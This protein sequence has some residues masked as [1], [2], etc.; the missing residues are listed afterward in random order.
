MTKLAD[1]IQKN[2]KALCE[3]DGYKHVKLVEGQSLPNMTRLKEI[4]FIVKEIVFPGFFSEAGSNASTQK[5]HLG[6]QMEKLNFLLSEQIRNGLLFFSEIG[7]AS[8]RERV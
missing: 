6:M 2:I 4:V 1:L 3:C 8:C 7:R 5:Y